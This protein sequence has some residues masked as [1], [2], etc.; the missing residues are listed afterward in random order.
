LMISSKL[1]PRSPLEFQC[2]TAFLSFIH[3]MYSV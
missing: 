2:A 1:L 3:C